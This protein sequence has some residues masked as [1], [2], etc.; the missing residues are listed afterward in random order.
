MWQNKLTFISI[1]LIFTGLSTMMGTLGML[2][3]QYLIERHAS[4]LINGPFDDFFV[5]AAIMTALGIGNLILFMLVE[6]DIRT[7]AVTIGIIMGSAR[8]MFIALEFYLFGNLSM[9][10]I[11]LILM[12]CY[13]LIYCIKWAVTLNEATWFGSAYKRA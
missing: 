9:Y 6:M 1:T 10:D 4:Q 5:V 11:V 3:P 12:A 2:F 8:I 7:P 13:Q